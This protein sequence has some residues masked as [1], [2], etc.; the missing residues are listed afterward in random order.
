METVLA[1]L[2][3]S[4]MYVPRALGNAPGSKAA[5]SRMET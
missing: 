3:P 4:G 1:C 5:G 2:F